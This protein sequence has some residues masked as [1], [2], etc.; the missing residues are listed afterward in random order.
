VFLPGEASAS[1]A[2][3][4]S[5]EQ[6][7]PA[8]PELFAGHSYGFE[9]E[10]LLLDQLLLQQQPEGDAVLVARWGH[11][12]ALPCPS[13]LSGCT[14]PQDCTQRAG[15]SLTSLPAS[16]GVPRGWEPSS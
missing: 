8:T 3:T 2:A 6:Q 13:A 4:S 10:L 12:P 14:Q 11:W 16:A 7:G 5:Q 9:G 15:G 1:A